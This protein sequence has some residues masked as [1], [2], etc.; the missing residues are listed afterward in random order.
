[1]NTVFTSSHPSV[2]RYAAALTSNE[3]YL[4]KIA[5]VTEKSGLPKVSQEALTFDVTRHSTHTIATN[6]QKYGVICLNNL[7][8]SNM[9]DGLNEIADGVFSDVTHS[10][11]ADDSVDAGDLGYLAWQKNLR[12]ADTFNALLDYEK[13]IV[14]I[15]GSAGSDTG[16]M[17]VFNIQKIPA[18]SADKG[19]KQLFNEFTHGR[20][21]QLVRQVSSF[22]FSN[23]QLYENRSVL[24]TRGF[25]IDNIFGT[26]K[27]FVYLTDVNSER[28]GPYCYVPGSHRIPYLHRL[29]LRQTERSG[30][31]PRD[32][33]SSEYLPSIRFVA[34]RG[35][36]IVSNQT[37]IH[38]GFPQQPGA[39]RRVMV[40]NYSDHVK[41][42][43][44]Y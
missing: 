31:R 9:C 10:T 43:R 2:K 39:C 22:T 23:V 11:A 19:F 24:D 34:P 14:N 16:M 44:R 7:V 32:M 8:D 3:D 36:V 1:M 33:L 4:K 13:P 42:G 21:D 26:Y 27:V 6:L 20:I 5:A 30:I 15:R 35:T 40:A 41:M 37:G 28:E 17:D 18:L 25:H 38:R 12:L 29:E